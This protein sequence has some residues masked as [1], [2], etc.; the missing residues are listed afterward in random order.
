MSLMHKYRT[1]LGYRGIFV[2]KNRVFDGYLEVH[3]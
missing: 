1:Y 3:G 2:D